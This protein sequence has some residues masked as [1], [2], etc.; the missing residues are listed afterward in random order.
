MFSVVHRPP[1]PLLC[2]N[3]DLFREVVLRGNHIK[4]VTL[5]I[6]QGLNI[7]YIIHININVSQLQLLVMQKKL[8]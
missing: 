2:V 3:C 5:F 1:L 8:T 6:Y 4:P 7:V